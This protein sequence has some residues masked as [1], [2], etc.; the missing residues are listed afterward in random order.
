MP[1]VIRKLPLQPVSFKGELKDFLYISMVDPESSSFFTSFGIS[2]LESLIR[3]KSFPDLTQDTWTSLNT[4]LLPIEE[5][6]KKYHVINLYERFHDLIS[7][8]YSSDRKDSMAVFQSFVES[9]NLLSLDF[10]LRLLSMN[11]TKNPSLLKGKIRNH[12]YV[13]S[14]LSQKLKVNVF[15]AFNNKYKTIKTSNKSPLI[16]LYQVSPGNFAVLYHRA[17]KYLDEKPDPVHIDPNGFPFTDTDCVNIE[18]MEGPSSILDLIGFLSN[19]VTSISPVLQR[20]LRNKIDAAS[21]EIPAISTINTLMSLVDHNLCTHNAP[22]VMASCGKMHCKECL[23]LNG[24]CSCGYNIIQHEP[25]KNTR[26]QSTGRNRNAF[27]SRLSSDVVAH[28]EKIPC[29]ECRKALDNEEYAL[30]S[31]KGHYIC[32]RCRA[33]KFA[34]GLQK[35]PLC[36]REYTNDEKAF[37]STPF[38]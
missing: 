29:S 24:K 5:S 14:V 23:S 17:V 16:C 32:I 33:R 3:L 11:L 38:A 6:A 20:Q 36:L 13:L 9:E 34:K 22:N 35:C 15:L 37:L 28:K 12:D 4:Y 30:I 8:L 31:C 25:P 10:C 26:S 27:A 1:M 7:T 19:Q 2:L 18:S 21:K